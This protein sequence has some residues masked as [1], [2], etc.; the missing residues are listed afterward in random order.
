MEVDGFEGLLLLQR[1]LDFDKE[2]TKEEWKQVYQFLVDSL[3]CVGSYE[4]DGKEGF[5]TRTDIEN[6]PLLKEIKEIIYEE[7]D[8]D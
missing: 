6:D 1:A 7:G 4:N 8:D 2:L 3:A 5:P